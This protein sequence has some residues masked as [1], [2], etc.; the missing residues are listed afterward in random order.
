VVHEPTR[1]TGTTSNDSTKQR[2]ACFI[3]IAVAAL[4]VGPSGSESF[5]S[6]LEEPKLTASSTGSAAV[7]RGGG[8]AVLSANSE[9]FEVKHQ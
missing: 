6:E 9:A 4:Q 5:D 8:A 1:P 2:K 3:E 7:V